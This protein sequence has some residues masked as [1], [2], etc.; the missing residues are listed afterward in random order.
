MLS[1]IYVVPVSQLFYAFHQLEFPPKN[2]I[3]KKKPQTF[4]NKE[5]VKEKSILFSEFNSTYYAEL[6]FHNFTEIQ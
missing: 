1:I 4:M 2:Y 3:Y 6:Y 5:Y